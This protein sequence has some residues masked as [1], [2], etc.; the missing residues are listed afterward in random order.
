MHALLLLCA[1][2]FGDEVRFEV[3]DR[4]GRG[5]KALPVTLSALLAPGRFHDGELCVVVRDG[6]ADGKPAVVAAQV[7]LLSRHR[8]GSLQHA[9]VT[10][11]LDLAPNAT[12]EV[13]L[14]PS[15]A[16][17]RQEPFL[18]R[19]PAP[20]VA[21]ELLARDG[22]RFTAIVE[23]PAPERANARGPVDG[24]LAREL[25]QVATLRSP[26][27]ELPRLS[28]R[29]RWRQLAGIEGARVEVVLENTALGGSGAP[30]PDDVE[31]A[32]LVVIAGDE[33][34]ADLRDGIVWDRTRFAVRRH[35]GGEPPNVRVREDLAYLTLHGWIPPYDA[36]HPLAP[37]R[38]DELARRLIDG[39]QNGSL[40]AKRYEVGIPL[41]PGPIARYMPSTGDRGDIGPIPSWG[42]LALNSKSVVADD[43]LRAADWNGAASFPIHVRGRDG[44]MGVEFGAAKALEKRATKRKCP[45]TADRSHSP[46]LGALSFLLTGERFAEEEFAALAAY[47]FYDWPHD[48]R[49][50]YPGSRDFAWSLRTT[51]L[52]AQLLPD[53][54]PLKGYFRK[55]VTDN[56]AEL[57][58]T[59]EQSPA[60]LHTWG[61]GGFQSSGRKTWV[62]ATFW[63]PWQATWVATSCWWTDRLLGN[64]DAR[65]LWEWQAEYF[66][67]AYASVGET[68]RAPDGTTVR[69]ENGATALSYSFPVSTF[70]PTL[71]RGEW[72]Q[73]A[74]SRRFIGSFAEC[75]WWLR[76]NLDH[77]FDPGKQPSLP[78]GVDGSAG[79]GPETW[80]PRGGFTP[81][82]VPAA[83]WITYAMH[84]FAAV[85]VADELPGAAAIDAQV[86]P[87]IEAE[88]DEP[89]LRMVPA[90]LKG[91]R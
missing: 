33:V 47:C 20:P 87:V 29:V 90:A 14:V 53:A 2:L 85:A 64:A 10:L 22:A 48:G 26:E 34:L 80:R 18:E 38:A 57:R 6:S 62:C 66:A 15:P 8:D 27:G 82:P 21:V 50:R 5:A 12:R 71:E 55:R 7:D 60:P 76:V 89:G 65:F 54:H 11:P 58:A 81:P 32:R 75:A 3:S 42:A 30:P 43:L 91:P 45:Q 88:I 25:E 37:A 86:R 59:I 41:D 56:L 70:V 73:V 61:S 51:M 19:G 17:P 52:A 84:W 74:D 78:N 23:A 49:Y 40:D 24:P 4:S 63:S 79:L 67:R 31:F 72:K 68:W 35:V 9:L 13:W 46:L 44:T 39:D 1:A 36:R 83:S 77:Q 28:V 16:P 69:W